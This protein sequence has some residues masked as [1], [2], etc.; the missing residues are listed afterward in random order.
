[1]TTAITAPLAL[2]DAG[3]ARSFTARLD[4]EGDRLMTVVGT[5]GDHRL[6]IEYRWQVRVPDYLIVAAEARHLEGDGDVLDPALAARAGAI[7]G[8]QASQGFTRAMREAL[9]TGR[10]VREH[11]ALAIDM[12]R[13]SLQG[14]PVPP[15]DHERFASQA[16]GI[17]NPSSRL[18]RMAW[19]RDRADW[20]NVCNT[21]FAYRDESAPLFAEREVR[22][23]DLDLVSPEPGQAG[24]FSR[25]K[26]LAVTVRADGSGYDLAHAMRDSFH[27]LDVA[28]GL[29]HDG[30]VLEAGNGWRRLAFMGICEGG[31]HGLPTLRGQRLDGA[32]ARAVADHVG[33]RNGCSHLF[34]LTVDCLRF[35]DWAA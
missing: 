8:S 9:G 33:G 28:L 29:G 16:A 19:E 1:M 27:D 26:E 22:C 7:A 30:T 24:F 5:L 3:Y 32:Y 34:D 23:F 13:A 17:D 14:F 2:P 21:C 12:A 11:L 15:G 35:F 4:Y 31:Q 18:A 20:G 6:A 10:G 25:R